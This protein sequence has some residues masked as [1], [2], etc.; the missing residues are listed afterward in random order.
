MLLE[1]L[2]ELCTKDSAANWCDFLS[3]G[4][5]NLGLS[6]NSIDPCLFARKNCTIITCLDDCLMFDKDE[7]VLRE[8]VSSLEEKFRLT[9]ERDL[10]TFLGINFNKKN[11]GNLEI[12]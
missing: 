10:K 9:N 1:T 11:D 12:N 3:N 8:M 2:I 7:K 5:I 4:L 6:K